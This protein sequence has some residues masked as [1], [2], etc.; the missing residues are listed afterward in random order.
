MGIEATPKWLWKKKA[1][2]ALVAFKNG[3]FDSFSP[4]ILLLQWSDD[5]NFIDF[6]LLNLKDSRSRNADIF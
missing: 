5:S 6:L 3:F 2:E 4:L 1:L